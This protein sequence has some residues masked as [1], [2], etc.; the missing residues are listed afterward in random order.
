MQVAQAGAHVW[1]GRLDS[2][3]SVARALLLEASGSGHPAG[4]GRVTWG[5]AAAASARGRPAWPLRLQA[6]VSG[7]SPSQTAGP[8]APAPGRGRPACQP[9][10]QGRAAL[11]GGRGWGARNPPPPRPPV[12]V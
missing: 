3:G 2:A 10:P 6:R 9:P 1:H 5:R 7:T 11:P 8:R 12:P 4:W